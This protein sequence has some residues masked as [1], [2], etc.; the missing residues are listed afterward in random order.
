MKENDEFILDIKRLG[1]NGE[2]IGFYNKLAV[3]VDDAIPGEGHNVKITKVEP[4]MAYAKSLEIKHKSEDRIEPLCKHYYECGGCQVMHIR[5]QKMLE[6]KRESIIEAFNRYTK[7]NPKTFEIKPTIPSKLELGYR[8]R[9]ILP[10]NRGIDGKLHVCMIK[11]NTNYLTPIDDCPI[12][13]KLINNI[14]NQIIDLANKINITPYIH[15]YNR[16]ILRYISI[17][18][19]RKNEALV[20]L[21]CGEKSPKIKELAEQISKIDGVVGVYE[22]FNMDK[23]AINPFGDE[24]NHLFGEE[25]IIENLG[26]IRY[27]IYPTTFFQLNTL[28]AEALIENVK[29]LA[30]LSKKETV[31]DAYCGVGAIG[32]YLAKNSKEVIGIESN[33]ESVLAAKDNAK[34]NYISNASFYTGDASKIITDMINKGKSFDVAIV[35]PPRTGLDDKLLYTLHESNIKRIIYVS[36]NPSTLAKN[37]AKLSEKYKINQI[38]PLDLFPYTSHVETICLLN[39][40]ND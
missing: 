8:N 1:I 12:Q 25:Y 30:K 6:F 2:G 7:I 28:Q 10:V 4:K 11:A 27:K 13:D 39:R 38:I 29:K 15:K 5:Y 22:N 21:I 31:L 37:I 40:R 20:T 26:D 16:G 14:N 3:F 9:S 24:T 19:N 36:C 35:D 23:K 33:P 34:M 18:V 17:R 32:L